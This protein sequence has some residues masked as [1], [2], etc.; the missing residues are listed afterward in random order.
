MLVKWKTIWFFAL[1]SLILL[2][3]CAPK[4]IVSLPVKLVRT[5]TGRGAEELRLQVTVAQNAN[6]NTPVA[7]D[8]VMVADKDLLKQISGMTAV[9]WFGKRSQIQRDYTK[10]V[11]FKSWEWVPGTQAPV[12]VPLLNGLKG[13]VLFAD[14]STPGDHRA[15]LDPRRSSAISL[16]ETDF[17]VGDLT[18]S[19][20]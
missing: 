18:S 13:A 20:K 2:W 16:L 17:T 4:K 6:Q 15:I 14:Y 10:K 8:L 1:G 9:Q 5:A 19:V 7:V 3:G 12:S 11:E